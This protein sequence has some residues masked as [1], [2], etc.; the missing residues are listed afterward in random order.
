MSYLLPLGVT[1]AILSIVFFKPEWIENVIECGINGYFRI[2]DYVYPDMGR[3]DEDDDDRDDKGIF[4]NIAF[5]SID[6]KPINL[7]TLWPLNSSE[8]DII[9]DEEV[10]REMKLQEWMDEQLNQTE[11]LESESESKSDSGSDHLVADTES[12]TEAGIV[13]NGGAGEIK[14]GEHGSGGDSDHDDL[15]ELHPSLL[16]NVVGGDSNRKTF[17]EVFDDTAN[18]FFH[19]KA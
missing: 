7:G 13:G 10:P 6:G 16:G 4:H 1:A 9:T 5:A 2:E 18:N 8:I 11:R 19:I 3:D 12:G 15:A 14:N 17:N